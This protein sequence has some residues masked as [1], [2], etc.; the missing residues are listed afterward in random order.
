M[1]TAGDVN[2]PLSSTGSSGKSNDGMI[3][4]YNGKKYSIHT[5]RTDDHKL[6]V[7]IVQASLAK[8]NTPFTSLEIIPQ[9][10][11]QH[12]ITQIDLKV[13][14]ETT[15]SSDT[16]QTTDDV[17]KKYCS[18]FSSSDSTARLPSTS[19]NTIQVQETKKL[20]LADIKQEA[21]SQAPNLLTNLR[22]KL[23]EEA[24]VP[25]P[26]PKKRP[27]APAALK[28]KPEQLVT[29]ERLTA[30]TEELNK[31]ISQIN[32]NGEVKLK[33]IKE[34]FVESIKAFNRDAKNKIL[35]EV[36]DHICDQWI[37]PS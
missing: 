2:L 33:D 18:Q 8:A 36:L 6:I 5:K 31:A 22:K 21:Q 27:Q 10:N 32:P 19:S 17:F 20:T 26:K 9:I 7:A 24:L 35:P 28:M 14:T 34:A 13:F 11:V 30:C 23:T 15:N 25:K 29:K 12:Q 4:D 1:A 3:I 37:N 16:I